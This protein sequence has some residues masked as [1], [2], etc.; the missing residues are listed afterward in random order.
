[1]IG[2]AVAL[3][4]AAGIHYEVTASAAARELSI[5]AQIP[6]FP[7]R[8]GELSVD[9]GAE[10]FVRDVAV[11]SS[12]GAVPVERRGDSWFAPG[13]AARGCTIRYRFALREAAAARDDEDVA[14]R[15][16]EIVESPPGA[17]LLRPLRVALGTTAELSVSTPEGLRFVAGLPPGP[18]SATALG[19]LPYAAFGALRVE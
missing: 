18:V 10:A 5:E 14:V 3:V 2:F 19:G 17:W 16:G 6:A 15:Y 13:C 12:Q 1:M 8:D 7:D 11:V 9:D 4:A